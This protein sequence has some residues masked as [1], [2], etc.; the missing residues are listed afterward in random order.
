MSALT[1]GSSV[2]GLQSYRP[3]AYLDQWVWIRMARAVSGKPDS[4]GDPKLLDALVAAADAG[5]AFPLSWTHYIETEGIKNPRQRRDVSDVMAAISHFRTI[6]SRRDLLRNQLLV[7]MHEQFG[8]PTFRPQN[9][10]PLGVGVHWAFQGVEKTLQVHDAGGKVIDIEEFP[11]EMRVRATQ[12]FEY[13]VMAGPHGDEEEAVLRE[14]Y[15]YKPEGTAEV[16]Q[17]R[18]QWE[19]EFVGLLVDTPPKDPTELRVWIQAREVLHENLELLVEVFKEYGLPIRRLTGGFD[20]DSERRREFIAGFFDRLPSVRVAV[21]LKLAVHR[22]NQRGWA[23]NDVYDTDA[24]SIAVPYCAVV[25]TDKAAADALNR[26]RA[27]ERLGTFITAKLAEL[28]EVLPEMV[29]HAKTLPDPSG[30]ET[31]SPGVGFNPLTLDQV[32]EEL[33]G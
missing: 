31:F 13:Q 4:P 30:W 14:R 5:V 8:R 10:D 17:S 7:A 33:R 3:T 27:G 18:L 1:Q 21:D 9:L 32:V 22:N 16:G 2:D 26:A 28:S 20:N 25:V 15:G 19:Q 12:G 11:R 24:M 23:K 6:R 29:Q